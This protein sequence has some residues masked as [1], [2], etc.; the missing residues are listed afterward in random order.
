MIPYLFVFI[1][2][3]FISTRASST[4]SHKESIILLFF[5]VIVLSSLAGVR[6]DTVGRDMHV[7]V[8][9]IWDKI[10][11][12][13][14]IVEALVN[15]ELYDVEI[16]Y[17]LLNYC[18]SRFTEDFHWLLFAIQFISTLIIAYIL[19]KERSSTPTG[20]V[21]MVYML[22]LYVGSFNLVRQSLAICF[23]VLAYFLFIYKNKIIYKFRYNVIHHKFVRDKILGILY[24]AD[25][26]NSKNG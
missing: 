14:N 5:C 16:G 20:F 18:V 6:D 15:A 12:S 17:I 8:L 4:K 22:H 19:F 13:K 1:I 7:Y 25:L 23:F 9:Y 21:M 11:T 24:N 10:S 3:G 26:K 2:V